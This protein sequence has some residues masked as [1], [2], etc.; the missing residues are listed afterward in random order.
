MVPAQEVDDLDAVWD[1]IAR[2]YTGAQPVQPDTRQRW[3]DR[4]F[5]AESDG[6]PVGAYRAMDFTCSRLG[7]HLP[8]AGIAGVASAPESRRQ[9][10][11]AAMMRNAIRVARETGVPLL[12]LYAFR[13]TYYRRFGYEVAGERVRITCPATRWPRVE[14]DLPVRHLGN[15]YAPVEPCFEQF[16]ERYAGGTRRDASRWERV[17]EPSDTLYAFG[18][19]AEAYVILRH[20][21][22]FWSEDSFAEVVWSSERGYRAI[23]AFGE[24]MVANKTGLH[25]YEPNPSPF[26]TRYLDQG[27]KAEIERLVMYRVAHVPGAL[28]G[29][30]PQESGTFSFAV[31]DPEVPENEGP[32]RVE[33]GP[34]FVNVAP[35]PEADLSLSIWSFAQAFLGQPSLADLAVLDRIEVTNASGFEAAQRLLPPQSVYC[36][37]FY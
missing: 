7:A 25:W 23:L 17:L 35:A 31:K 14:S 36:L 2:T 13:E 29:L 22:S 11:G 5:V 16:L 8:C 3:M 24:Q 21:G 26:L 33:F 4:L 30:S 1:L 32:W 28:K 10:V 9:G 15:D 18:D 37:D 6:R 20:S 34:G 19:P 27:I 12:A